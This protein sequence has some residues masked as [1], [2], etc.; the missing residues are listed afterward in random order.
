MQEITPNGTVVRTLTLKGSDN[1]TINDIRGI[2]YNPATNDL[3]VTELGHSNAFF[4]LLRFDATTGAFEKNNV[5][6][7]GDDIVLTT[8]GEL[9]VGSRTQS[10]AFFNQ[11]LNFLGTTLQGGQQMF[12]TQ[13]VPEPS[14]LSLIAF[15]LAGTIAYTVFRKRSAA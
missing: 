13:F 5:F 7:Y 6:T 1:S 12:V 14:V 10:P 15:A 11:D 2:E 4:Q 3:F 9:L 8:S